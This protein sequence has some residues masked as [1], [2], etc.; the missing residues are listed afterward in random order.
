MAKVLKAPDRTDRWLHDGTQLKLVGA[1]CWPATSPGMQLAGSLAGVCREAVD[2]Y[3]EQEEKDSGQPTYRVEW[4]PVEDTEEL[5]RKLNEMQYWRKGKA[6]DAPWTASL[7]SADLAADLAPLADQLRDEYRELK[8]EDRIDDDRWQRGRDQWRALSGPGDDAENVLNYAR[9]EIEELDRELPAE[10]N[11]DKR[12]ALRTR[13]K[14]L[15]KYVTAA[16]Q[17]LGVALAK[18]SLR[19]IDEEL[20]QVRRDLIRETKDEKKL[21]DLRRK[22]EEL[23]KKHKAAK[24]ALAAEQKEKPSKPREALEKAEQ[25]KSAT[26]DKATTDLL[27]HVKDR[28]PGLEAGLAKLHG[29]RQEADSEFAH[30][31]AKSQR[32]TREISRV[33]RRFHEVDELPGKLK[34]ARKVGVWT[35]GYSNILSVFNW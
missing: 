1:M 17:R 5:Q 20:E 32:L 31:V 10:K 14:A 8:N 22:K 18:E 19:R 34:R 21:A 27:K 26:L 30:V 2:R 25:G 29:P 6:A 9:R 7:D 23:E 3:R 12:A 35:D 24:E 11:A 15:D 33:S 4:L 16:E 28:L 13:L